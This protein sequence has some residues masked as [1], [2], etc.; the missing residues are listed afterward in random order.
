MAE[1]CYDWAYFLPEAI[2]L[3]ETATEHINSLVS[4][5]ENMQ[6]II[7]LQKSLCGGRPILVYPGRRLIKEGI[8]MKVSRISAQ[9]VSKTIK[10]KF[11]K[12]PTPHS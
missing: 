7:E 8:L 3:V 5:Q 6:R 9:N 12:S 10:L 1:F 4:E 11:E 2:R